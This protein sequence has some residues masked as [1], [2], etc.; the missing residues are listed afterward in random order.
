MILDSYNDNS[1][2]YLKG[3]FNRITK[4]K[5]ANRGLQDLTWVNGYSY[6]QIIILSMV[7]PLLIW[8]RLSNLCVIYEWMQNDPP[9]AL[10]T[11]CVI[12]MAGVHSP[13]MPFHWSFKVKNVRS[14]VSSHVNI[15]VMWA[16]SLRYL[17]LK[18]QPPSKIQLFV[19]IS[20]LK[21][22][23]PF[24]KQCPDNGPPLSQ[25]SSDNCWGLW[26]LWIIQFLDWQ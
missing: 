6:F 4:K 15:L 20:A 5:V 13:Q 25:G 22:N 12:V 26:S 10:I 9:S 1:L 24:Q 21:S 23:R 17:S 18:S 2:M 19:S 8:H 16:L 14:L 3:L 7:W 11:W